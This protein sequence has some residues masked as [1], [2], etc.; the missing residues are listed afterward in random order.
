MLASCAPAKKK[1]YETLLMDYDPRLSLFVV[2]F[3]FTWSIFCVRVQRWR[4]GES[5]RLPPMWLGFRFPDPA[6]YVG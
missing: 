6:S 3:V 4:S 5:T 2:K 1:P